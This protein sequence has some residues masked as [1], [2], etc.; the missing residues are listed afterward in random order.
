MKNKILGV[1][2]VVWGV[3]III[4]WLLTPVSGNEAYQVGKLMSV[5]FGIALALAGG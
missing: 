1:I 2:G 4:N 5:F 3:A